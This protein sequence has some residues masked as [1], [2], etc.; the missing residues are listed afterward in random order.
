MNKDIDITN[1]VLHTERLLLRAWQ[2]T[3]LDDFFEYASVDGVGQM[4]GWLPHKNKE[5]TMQILNMF[6][7]EKKTFAIVYDKKVIGSVGIERYNESELPEYSDKMGREIEYV[8]SK[9]YWGQ[10]I[11][12]E[13]VQE[14]IRWL[15]DEEKLDFIVCGHFDYNMR[16]QR[17]QEKCGFVHYKMNKYETQYGKVED[18]WISVLER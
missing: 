10:G 16:S 7:S 9:D 15:F 17:V 11:M 2:E 12:T 6:I 14:V 4:A 1:V 5:E 13:A 3:D 8:L 18:N